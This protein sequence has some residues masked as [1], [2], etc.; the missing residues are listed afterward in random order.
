MSCS[1]GLRYTDS[2]HGDPCY[3]HPLHLRWTS[4]ELLEL[5]QP[6]C[7]GSGHL[8]LTQGSGSDYHRVTRSAWT[9]EQW[10][11]PSIRAPQELCQSYHGWARVAA[12]RRLPPWELCTGV[13]MPQPRLVVA[14][15]CNSIFF[16]FT[17]HWL[18]AFAMWEPWN[19]RESPSVL[20]CGPAVV[21]VT[22][23]LQ[24]CC[25]HSW[26]RSYR[27]WIPICVL[28]AT[29]WCRALCAIASCPA[30]GGLGR[31]PEMF[32]P[33]MA[34]WEVPLWRSHSDN[35]MRVVTSPGPLSVFTPWWGTLWVG[36]PHADIRPLMKKPW[37]RTMAQSA[38]RPGPSTVWW[39]VIRFSMK[40]IGRT[41]ATGMTEPP[42]GDTLPLEKKP[43]TAFVSK[44]YLS[45]K[46]KECTI[47]ITSL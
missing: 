11:V 18:T 23:L 22:S 12:C 5:V 17:F 7:S 36:A 30:Q 3:L 47:E 33:L 25:G 6:T 32:P 39:M 38:P 20:T 31:P 16:Y 35:M 21:H 10:G 2:C 44:L 41:D 14:I 15:T 1:S 34:N 8:E 13:I 4:S 26:E 29:A 42:L 28:F 37:N 46:R 27:G 40:T 19:V 9:V 43:I 24:S 45:N